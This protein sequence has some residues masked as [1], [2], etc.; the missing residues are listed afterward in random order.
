MNKSE[1]LLRRKNKSNQ[2]FSLSSLHISIFFA[3]YALTLLMIAL[4]TSVLDATANVRMAGTCMF[5]IREGGPKT[6]EVEVESF[7]V[8][9][10]FFL[11]RKILKKTN[12]SSFFCFTSSQELIAR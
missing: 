3:S 7:F 8:R 12:Q 4:S 2:T 6:E 11:D 5:L 1:E 9:R 10:R